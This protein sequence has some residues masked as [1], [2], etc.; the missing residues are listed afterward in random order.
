[1]AGGGSTSQQSSQSNISQT[2]LPPWV[3][4]AAQQNYGLAQSV[5]ARPLTQ[6]GGQQVA[7]VGP[8]MQQGWNLAAS[9]GGAGADQY[10]AAQ[11][12]FLTAAGTPATQVTPQSLAGTN[13]QSVHEPVHT[14]SHRQIDAD[15]PTAARLDAEPAAERGQRGQRLRRQSARRA[16]G[17]DPGAGRAGHGADG[18][19]AE[20]SQLRPSAGGGDRRHLAATSQRSKATKAPIRPTSIRSSRRRAALAASAIRRSRTSVSNSSNCRRLARSSSNR[21][22]PR[23]MRRS[24][25]SRRPTSIRASSSASCN[26]RW[27]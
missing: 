7:D 17:R 16:A 9:S 3:N 27:A 1:M 2:Q 24:S 5:A 26:R 4:Q 15:L 18:G 20:P 13:L 10:N 11:A 21:R 8:Q 12:G 22:R 23:S 6:Y 14:A 25:N 19:A